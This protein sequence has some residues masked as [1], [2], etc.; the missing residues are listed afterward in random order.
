MILEVN[1]QTGEV[2]EQE[3]PDIPTPIIQPQEPTIDDLKKQLAETD[4]R[5]IK[6]YEYSLVGL[7]MPYDVAELHAIRQAIRDQ[8]A[9]L[10]G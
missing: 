5:A 1:C 9:E 7:P 10:E 2:T 8:I 4:Y 3:T 6:C